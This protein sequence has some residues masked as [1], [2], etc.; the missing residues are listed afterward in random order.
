MT[1]PIATNVRSEA[2]SCEPSGTLNDQGWLPGTFVIPTGGPPYLNPGIAAKIAKTDGTVSALGFTLYGSRYLHAGFDFRY[3]VD[4]RFQK[5]TPDE[6]KP[7]TSVRPEAIL[8]LDP[9][10]KT[11]AHLGSGETAVVLYATG[12]YTIY[13]YE[14]FDREYRD[15]DGASGSPLVYAPGDILYVSSRSLFTKEQEV[16]GLV[17]HIAAGYMVARI[18]AGGDDNKG[19]YLM[20]TSQ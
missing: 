8:E 7:N 2:I 19:P 14:I 1:W 10:D 16:T 20:I 4:T 3:P 18:S 13:T 9:K 5:W 11:L 15:S 6:T 12:I 17:T